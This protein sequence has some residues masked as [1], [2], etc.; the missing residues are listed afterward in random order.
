MNYINSLPY[1]LQFKIL[2]ESDYPDIIKL[3]QGN[4]SLSYLCNDDYLWEQ[5]TI[6]DYP[7]LYDSKPIDISFKQLYI[8][9]YHWDLKV[10]NDYPSIY[11]FKEPDDSYEDFYKEI[12]DYIEDKT[13]ELAVELGVDLEDFQM[14]QILQLFKDYSRLGRKSKFSQDSYQLEVGVS[15]VLQ[16]NINLDD[17]LTS[18][19][20]IN[21]DTANEINRYVEN[22]ID[23]LLSYQKVYF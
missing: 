20:F 6:R 15:E 16:I 7:E 5:L 1:E 9:E 13:I 8:N 3:C 4:K 14:V 19:V 10:F 18:E 22:I 21:F 11:R 17:I 2:L 23:F 12:E